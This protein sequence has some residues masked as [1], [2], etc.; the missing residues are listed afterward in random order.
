MIDI[1]KKYKTRT[2]VDVRIYATDGGTEYPVHGAITYDGKW[3]PRDWTA[4][5]TTFE[6][7]TQCRDDLIEVKPRIKREVWV[8]VYPGG[9]VNTRYTR[10]DA[11]D[12]ATSDRIACV[13]IVIDCEEGE[14]L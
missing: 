5:G 10:A 8:N 2:G 11:D 12:D 1:T 6:D 7:N 9:I 3:F 13:K 14:G 4:T